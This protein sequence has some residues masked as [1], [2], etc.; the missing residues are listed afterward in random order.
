MKYRLFYSILAGL[1]FL[2]LVGGCGS[3]PYKSFTLRSGV[4][5]FFFQYPARYEVRKTELRP[6]L[7]YSFVVLYG[8]YQEEE[9]D[10][11]MVT[12][13]VDK[14]DE[15]EPS[16]ETAVEHYLS[17]VSQRRDFRLLERSSIEVTADSIPAEQFVFSN[18]WAMRLGS[19][20]V[21]EIGRVVLFEHSNL[22]W[23]ISMC[24]SMISSDIYKVD[25]EH[26][27]KTFKILR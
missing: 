24:S 3:S 17:L 5:H 6:D 27:L 18:L 22:I 15:Y 7:G 25:F 13:A 21:T 10:F 2:F 1:L 11:A 9:K 8:P 12:V 14:A 23:E 4:G 16:A 19:E 20:P 26:I